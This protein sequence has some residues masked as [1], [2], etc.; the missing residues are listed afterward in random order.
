MAKQRSRTARSSNGTQLC[1]KDLEAFRLMLLERRMLEYYS[2]PQITAGDIIFAAKNG[3]K[4][5]SAKVRARERP[6]LLDNFG[7]PILP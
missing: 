3:A 4:L 2:A 1:E 7:N 6:R 5:N